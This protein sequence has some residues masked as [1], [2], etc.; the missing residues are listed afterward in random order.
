MSERPSGIFSDVHCEEGK[1]RATLLHDPSVEGLD[2]AIYMDGS[3]SMLDEYG[4]PHLLNKLWCWLTRQQVKRGP[5]QVEPQIKRMLQYLA[6]KDRNGCLK[7]AYWA[8]GNGKKIES[9]GELTAADVETHHFNGPT[10]FGSGTYLEP[11]LRDFVEYM[12][13]Q[14][15]EG[16]KR[17]CAIIVTDGQLS[18]LEGVKHY[19]EQI[20]GEINAGSLPPLNF[21]F[22][23]VGPGVNEEE[24]ETISHAE[25]GGIDHMWCHRIA[26]EMSDLAQMVAVL[27]DKSMS[28]ESSGRLLDEQGKVLAVYEGQIPAVLE[29][30]VP[31]GARKFALEIN[32]VKYEQ[33]IPEEEHH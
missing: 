17:G 20:A 11:A 28:I 14:A 23:G 7:V 29:F 26:E 15:K 3:G 22:V 10:E 19:N 21:V 27:V 25:Y 2:T 16:S 18:D 1:V 8:C 30:S 6:S 32:G 5:N 4:E 33:A 31:E 12:R 9:V 24:M 13:Q